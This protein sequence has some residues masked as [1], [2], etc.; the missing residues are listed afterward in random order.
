MGV[1]AEQSS[2]SAETAVM[3]RLLTTDSTSANCVLSSMSL[4]S[5]SA[6]ALFRCF[7][8]ICTRR[9]KLRTYG[10]SRRLKDPLDTLLLQLRVINLVF[11]STRNRLFQLSVGSYKVGAPVRPNLFG[12]SSSTF[13]LVENH[14]EIICFE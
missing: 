13:E 8:I 3:R 5:P 6:T 12:R 7:F 10:G 2:R 14:N 11:V 9:F 1:S 4:S